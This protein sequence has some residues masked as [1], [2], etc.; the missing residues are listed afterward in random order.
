MA[1]FIT[2]M[3]IGGLMWLFG[4]SIEDKHH[5]SLEREYELRRK[6]REEAAACR[7]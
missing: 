1:I 5:K 2:G 4:K 7:R 6:K 3:I